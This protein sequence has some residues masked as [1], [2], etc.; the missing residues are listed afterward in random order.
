MNQYILNYS[1]SELELK[2]KIDRLNDKWLDFVKVQL[3]NEYF[4][5]IDDLF[6]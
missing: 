3:G 6:V 1:E 5:N 4:G 2:D